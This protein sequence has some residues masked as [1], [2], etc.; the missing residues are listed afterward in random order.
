MLA[1]DRTPLPFPYVQMA[2]ALMLIFCLSLPFALTPMFG[3]GSPFVSLVFAMAYGGLYMNACNLRNPFNYETGITGAPI[4]AYIQRLESV[5]ECLMVA[6][7][8]DYA[9]APVSPKRIVA[10]VQ[11]SQGQPVRRRTM[12]PC[13]SE[14][15]DTTDGSVPRSRFSSQA[16]LRTDVV[17]SIGVQGTH[18][19]EADDSTAITLSLIHI[20]EPTRLLSISY[21]VFC[22]KKK[23][24]KDQHCVYTEF[25]NN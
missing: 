9:S 2:A 8:G 15:E 20:S 13:F 10:N 11:G 1:I 6:V 14:M 3:W 22:L 19:E 21:A 24:I 18:G 16:S 23:N 17:E 12:S 7:N 4:N 25:I 5:T